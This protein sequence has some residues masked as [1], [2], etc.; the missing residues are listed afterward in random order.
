MNPRMQTEEFQYAYVCPLSAH[1][2]LNR[3]VLLEFSGE[4]HD[5]TF[6]IDITVAA[7][8]MFERVG[9]AVR[10]GEIRRELVASNDL[11]EHGAPVTAVELSIRA[12]I[13]SNVISGDSLDF[14]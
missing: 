5:R 14:A 1:A 11:D 8:P 2:G 4:K 7:S 3:D 9:A 6:E 13:A 10:V 12:T